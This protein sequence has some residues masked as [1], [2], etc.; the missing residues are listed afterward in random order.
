M[1]TVIIPVYNE[2]KFISG[3]INSVLNQDIMNESYEI[4]IT[5]GISDDKTRE[6]IKNFQ[7]E[8]E[9]IFLID[10][11]DKIVSIGFNKALSIAKGDVIIRLDG[12]AEFAPNYFRKC[13]NILKNKDVCCAGGIILNNSSSSIG[14]S[15]EIAQTSNF[16]VGGVAFRKN[17][18]KAKYVDTLAFGAYKKE[19]F[20]LYGGYDEELIKNQDDE[21][22]FRLIQNGNNIW[23]DPSLKTIYYSRE[24]FKKLFIQYFYYG[25]YKIRVIQKRQGFS[26]WRHIIPG[27]FVLGLII[28]I[29]QKIIYGKSIIFYSIFFS[30]SILNVFSMLFELFKKLRIV[31]IL[32]KINLILYIPIAFLTMHLSYGL[33]FL[34]GI[35][36]FI[37]Y[38]DK[39]SIIDSNY[40]INIKA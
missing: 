37:N 35:I 34:F 15:I 29:L 26:S 12:H 7:R 33:G 14:K 24:S 1:I 36:Y 28:S 3:A 20:E 9:N 17:D 22:N 19:V 13:L 25:L 31:E 23:L 6:I 8:N 40:K 10:N 18:I 2:E 11:P 16:G 27:I 32:K 21:F 5:D 4:L 30:Y 38:W 39:K